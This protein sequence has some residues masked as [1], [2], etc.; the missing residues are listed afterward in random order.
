MKALTD[1]FR[2]GMPAMAFSA[3]LMFIFVGDFPWREPSL[4]RKAKC[5]AYYRILDFR[6]Y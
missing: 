1:A 4:F 2:I 6:A 3:V 5:K